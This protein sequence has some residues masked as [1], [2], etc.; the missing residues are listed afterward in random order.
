MQQKMTENIK[1]CGCGRSPT[2][3]CVDWHGLTN[4]EY[5]LKLHEW[6]IKYGQQLPNE[7]KK[8]IL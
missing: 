2:G 5:Q 3:Q 4:G 6:T 1:P 7:E 8:V